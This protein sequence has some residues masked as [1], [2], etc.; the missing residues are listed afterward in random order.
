MHIKLNKERVIK[1]FQLQNYAQNHGESNWYS[2]KLFIRL[3]KMRLF[4]LSL[5]AKIHF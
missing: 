4:L 5:S 2:C 1:N 3:R